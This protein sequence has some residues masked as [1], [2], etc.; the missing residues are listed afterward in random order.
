MGNLTD[1]LDGVIKKALEELRADPIPIYTFAL[2]H[3]HE[4]AIVSVCVDTK[5]S[6]TK[7]VRESNRWSM[8]Y[9]VEH[10]QNGS[11]QDAALFQAN[12]GRSLSFGDFARVNLGETDLDSDFVADESFYLAMVRA[13]I[14]H[15]Q[16][17]LSLAPDPEGVVFCCSTAD[18]EVGLVWS[19]V[20]NAELGAPPHAAPPHAAP[21]HP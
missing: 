8:N 14:A 1:F 13:V 21:P 3:D 9:F 10:V 16:D 5:D 11:Y 15:Q 2:Y 12:V 20:P 17:I 19:V 18:S 4:S 7:L 6:S